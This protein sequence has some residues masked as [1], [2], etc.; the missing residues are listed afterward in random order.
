MS[1]HQIFQYLLNPTESLELEI[2]GW[3]DLDEPQNKTTLIKAII[4]LA[5]HGGGKILIGYNSPDE[6][7]FEP[8]SK[9]S[10]LEKYTTDKINNLIDEYIEPPFHCEVLQ[11]QHPVLQQKFPL[12]IIPAGTVPIHSSKGGHNQELRG[13][14]FIR[15]A[16]PKS[17][18]PQ[19]AY[20]WDQL[21]SR[22]VRQNKENLLNDFR[23][24]IE[25]SDVTKSQNKADQEFS[26]WVKECENAWIKKN[27]S[28]ADDD[29]GKIKNG[30]WLISY[31]IK[32][33]IPLQ[34]LNSLEDNLKAALPGSRFAFWV[35]TN[36]K[37]IKPKPI[38][39][40]ELEC[41]IGSEESCSPIREVDSSDYWRYTTNGK[42]CL[43]NG[44]REDSREF[45]WNPKGFIANMPIKILA[46]CLLHAQKMATSFNCINSEIEF[47]CSW[48][49][50]SGRILYYLSHN[51]FFPIKEIRVG[52]F[53]NVPISFKVIASDVDRFLPE[54][55]Y[56]E[57]SPLYEA[58]NL[59][60]LSK[61]FVIETLS[62]F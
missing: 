34:S 56:K 19:T 38:N 12:V 27:N 44:Y 4:A 22:C 62:N 57:L 46:D 1:N 35:P 49:G 8:D 24:I 42:A 60:K 28:L 16:G 5:N 25:T 29:P 11:L 59:Y 2:K 18:T 47:L 41:W 31:K 7:N 15:R 21:I 20:E 36:I 14:Y 6:M 53:D 23:R 45:S 13:K 9:S 37:E 3:L 48:E 58:F 54:I 32:D 26:D 43:I 17:E 55:I 61:D 50:L 10:Q 39:T 30:R 33:A 40:N 51:Q 52:S